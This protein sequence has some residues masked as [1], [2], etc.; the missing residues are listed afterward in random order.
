MMQSKTFEELAMSFSQ[1]PRGYQWGSVKVTRVCSDKRI[2]FIV[3]VEAASSGEFVDVR[4][5]PRGNVL[6]VEGYRKEAN[7]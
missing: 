6:Q 3:R 2:G 1:I 5:S 7:K 4:V